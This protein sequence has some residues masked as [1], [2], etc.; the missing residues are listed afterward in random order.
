MFLGWYHTDSDSI[1]S[2]IF[3]FS[4]QMYFENNLVQRFPSSRNI[5]FVENIHSKLTRQKAS[6][7][8]RLWK[9]KIITNKHQFL[10]LKCLYIV[11]ENQVMDFSQL[12]PH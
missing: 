4:G 11:H 7:I 10:G 8:N 9:K 6:S 12:L 5:P 3:F 1:G 2:V